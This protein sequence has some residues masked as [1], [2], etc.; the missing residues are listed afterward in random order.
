M[1]K[2]ILSSLLLA[3]IFF[4][5][6]KEGYKSRMD[7]LS[8]ENAISYGRKQRLLALGQVEKLLT[9]K[10]P[11]G[12]PMLKS[13]VIKWVQKEQAKIKTRQGD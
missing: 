11:S 10:T 5:L 2:I 4:W 9:E 1:L 13:Q 8:E 12:K 6:W 7:R 3:F